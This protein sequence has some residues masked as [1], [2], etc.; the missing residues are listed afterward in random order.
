MGDVLRK[1]L[2]PTSPH[3][4]DRSTQMGFLDPPRPPQAQLKITFFRSHFDPSTTLALRDF[5][6]CESEA[7]RK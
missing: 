5:H 4:A 2:T 1:L 6:G 3:E 7:S